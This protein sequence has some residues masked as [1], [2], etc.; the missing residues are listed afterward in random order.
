M[1]A[2]LLDTKNRRYISDTRVEDALQRLL[3]DLYRRLQAFE[4]RE[5]I[6]KW[7]FATAYRVAY[8]C[9]RRSRPTRAGSLSSAES[10]EQ[11]EALRT[12]FDVLDRIDEDKR[13]RFVQRTAKL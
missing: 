13:S 10:A 9:W 3:A 4:H 8:E 11:A 1:H 5:P 12:V 2:H 6:S 7:L